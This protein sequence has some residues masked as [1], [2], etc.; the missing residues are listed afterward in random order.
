MIFLPDWALEPRLRERASAE[1]RS[2]SHPG[3][4]PEAD[5]REVKLSR[6]VKNKDPTGRFPLVDSSEG[7]NG[8][9]AA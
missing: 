1:P 4:D 7:Q 8:H 9:T 2:L 6:D 5:E 3:S